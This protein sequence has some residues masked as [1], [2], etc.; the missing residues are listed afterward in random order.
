M[1]TPD[2][3]TPMDANSYGISGPETPATP[4]A[5]DTASQ[6][7]NIAQGAAAQAQS[8]QPDLVHNWKT[9]LGAV[10]SGI[11]N[12]LKGA[13]E[14]FVTG[15]VLGAAA[16]AVNPN[17]AQTNYDAKRAVQQAHVQQS[18]TAAQQAQENLKISQDDH[19]GNMAMTHMN[20]LEAQRKYDLAPKSIQ[21]DIDQKEQYAAENLK[22]SG[23]QPIVQNIPI[24]N[25]ADA[26]AATIQTSH[27]K[28]ALNAIQLRNP[29]GKTVNI[30][31]VPDDKKLMPM[32]VD[33]PIYGPDGTQIGKRTLPAYT[34]TP[35]AYLNMMTTGE[36]A[37]LTN[38][39]KVAVQ[40]TKNQ[41]SQAVANIKSSAAATANTP[42]TPT[43]DSLGV[44]I[45]PPAGG[46][47]AQS[48]IQ[49]QFKKDADDLSKTE[50]TF[51][52]FQ[53]ALSD[54]N[55]GKDM[56]GAQS[57]VTLFNA[58]GL[59]ATPLKGMG[60]RIN[61]NTVAEHI[62]ARDVGQSLYAK[63]LGVKDGDIITPQQVKDYASI[64]SQ[65][66]QSAYVNKINEARSY[67][68]D[69]SFLLPSGNG[70]NVDPSTAA[71]FVAA[72]NGNKDAARKAAQAKGWKF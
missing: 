20:L 38:S 32:A 4:G 53:S 15:G 16:G 67:G 64:A 57:V 26:M 35:A 6:V 25:Q 66:R 40:Q 30:Y 17:F 11:G 49:G 58:I 24:G 63:L 51:D 1:N 43:A 55:S 19:S 65:S 27:E 60:M 52:Q 41:G 42:A 61:Q 5:I 23:I 56:T 31:A 10:M 70:R 68:L 21:D 72:A 18:Q 22:M 36:V 48:R 39:T 45:T 62:N 28:D 44:T 29:D 34:T 7:G 3:S 12:H 47:K 8:D 46:A 13:G 9:V 37:R 50:S 69:P 71:I 14:G 33:I 2:T 54:I 59:S